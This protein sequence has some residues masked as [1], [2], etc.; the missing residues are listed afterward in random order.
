MYFL[1]VINSNNQAERVFID[2]DIYLSE[3]EPTRRKKNDILDDIVLEVQKRNRERGIVVSR[4]G[5]RQ[6]KQLV[7]TARAT[8]LKNGRK[9]PIFNERKASD[10]TLF[11]DGTFDFNEV[12]SQNYNDDYFNFSELK[13]L[14]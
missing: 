8:L 11:N 1:D 14:L 7:K 6:I 13:R 3:F 5:K 2:K 12:R 10:Y 9:I 4:K